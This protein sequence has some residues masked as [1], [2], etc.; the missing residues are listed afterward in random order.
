MPQ[1][2]PPLGIDGDTMD[3]LAVL[4][5]EGEA[6]S[7]LSARVADGEEWELVERFHL[8]LAHRLTQLVGRPVLV[9][10]SMLMP[11]EEQLARQGGRDAARSSS[12]VWRV[13]GLARPWPR[14]A[15]FGGTPAQRAG[16][17]EVLEAGGWRVEVTD[18]VAASV[19]SRT[20]AMRRSRRSS[21]TGPGRS[22]SRGWRTG[23]T[24]AS[25]AIKAARLVPS[26]RDPR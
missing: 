11:E 13:D 24:H 7:A 5:D 20:G 3:D 16:G 8:A 21:M 25:S 6:I 19:V 10:E 26:F 18:W 17:T 14:Q 2:D 4:E 15:P 23:G 22:S 9:Y 12:L 1:L